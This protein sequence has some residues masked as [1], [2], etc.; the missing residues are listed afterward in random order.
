MPKSKPLLQFFQLFL[1]G[2]VLT[3]KGI[4]KISHHIVIGSI[5]LAFGIIILVYF[6]YSLLAKKPNE[7]LTLLAHWFEAIA[8]LFTAYI[9]FTEG[10]TYLPYLFLLAAVGFFIG[11]YVHHKKEHRHP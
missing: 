11:I 8:A 2:T 10:A 1:I 9:F 3:M 4:D 5:I 6:F 7:K